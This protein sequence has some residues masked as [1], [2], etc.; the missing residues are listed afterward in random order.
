M[1]TRQC[2][3][4]V[5][6]CATAV[7]FAAAW[8]GS[9]EQF[10]NFMPY[11]QGQWN[12]E[13]GADGAVNMQIRYGAGGGFTSKN[14]FLYGMISMQIKLPNNYFGGIIPSF[15]AIDQPGV[16]YHAPHDEIDFEFFG[17]DSPGQTLI[18]T[19]LL[20]GGKQFTEQVRKKSE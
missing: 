2:C 17:Q 12:C 11:C 4:L 10:F 15:Y 9:F 6:L 13:R 20:S 1:N 16:D 3:L 18:S 5:L 19:N 7:G 14:K 8:D